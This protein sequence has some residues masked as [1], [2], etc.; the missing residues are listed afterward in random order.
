[1]P[2][3]SEHSEWSCEAEGDVMGSAEKNMWADDAVP[4]C[5]NCLAA[6][7]PSAHFCV[8]CGAPLT[9]HAAIDPMGQV[10]AQGHIYRQAVG[11]PASALV[12]LG[13]WLIFLPIALA[14]F[15]AGR[16]VTTWVIAALALAV[17]YLVTRNYLRQRRERTGTSSDA[18]SDASADSRTRE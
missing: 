2:E 5:P 3:Q 6:N 4:L 11:R 1:M 13:V 17:L 18:S 12:L 15:L 10:Y 14:A 9:S 16:S 8:K 7:E